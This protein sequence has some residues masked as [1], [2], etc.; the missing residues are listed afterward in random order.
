MLL[1]CE[2]KQK[3]LWTRCWLLS[4]VVNCSFKTTPA[5]PVNMKASSLRLDLACDVSIFGSSHCCDPGSSCSSVGRVAGC[6]FLSGLSRLGFMLEV[7][8]MIVCA[9]NLIY[10]PRRC[11][12]VL[13]ELWLSEQRWWTTHCNNMCKHDWLSAVWQQRQHTTEG[14]VGMKRA[15]WVRRFWS[16]CVWVSCCCEETL[17]RRQW[18]QDEHS[19]D[20][21]HM[22]S[23]RKQRD[24]DV[25]GSRFSRCRITSSG[26]VRNLCWILLLHLTVTVQLHPSRPD[27]YKH[28]SFLLRRKNLT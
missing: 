18:K 27:I 12:F 8:I 21:T 7:V 6:R 25:T 19:Q 16:R 17:K 26:R 20:I 5:L 22:Q 9:L 28:T 1:N 2:Q 24:V 13:S 10:Y 4:R 23:S 3:G 11:W 14:T 15:G